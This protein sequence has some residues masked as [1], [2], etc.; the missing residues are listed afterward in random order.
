MKLADQLNNVE[1]MRERK[2][3]QIRQLM[4]LRK[5]IRAGRLRT[6]E[7]V[8]RYV[9]TSVDREL[10]ELDVLDEDIDGLRKKIAGR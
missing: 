8:E 10:Q 5:L 9:N 3:G 2:N 6:I 7:D 4:H 1:K